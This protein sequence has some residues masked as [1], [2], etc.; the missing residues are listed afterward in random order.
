MAI[1]WLVNCWRVGCVWWVCMWHACVCFCRVYGMC[2][3]YMAYVVMY[4]TTHIAPS[5]L[6]THSPDSL[7]VETG[8]SALI[9]KICSFLRQS[10]ILE[11][12]SSNIYATVQAQQ[13]CTL[14]SHDKL[15]FCTELLQWASFSPARLKLLSGGVDAVG[16]VEMVH[17]WTWI[18]KVIAQVLSYTTSDQLQLIYTHAPPLL[19]D[20][21]G[22]SFT[23]RVK[24]FWSELDG[25]QELICELVHPIS[26]S[27]SSVLLT[28]SVSFEVK[29]PVG[30]V[31]PLTTS[32]TYRAWSG[33]IL[34]MLLLDMVMLQ[35]VVSSSHQWITPFWTEQ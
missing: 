3:M 21:S 2:G 22:Q 6:T 13:L 8:N 14:A 9:Q 15:L 31:L 7:F 29:A 25:L 5:P 18:S 4:D 17:A 1:D 27:W 26:V 11:S 30:R 20:I 34:P 10:T 33:S 16:G 35:N 23:S 32:T 19:P 24:P 28:L 12:Y